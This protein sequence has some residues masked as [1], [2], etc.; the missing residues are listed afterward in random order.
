MPYHYRKSALIKKGIWLYFFLLLFEGALRKWI[1]PNLAAPLLI[2]RDPIAFWILLVSVKEKIIVANVYLTGLLGVGIVG[3]FT[4]IFLGHG[5]MP[6]AIFGARIFLLHLPLIFVIGQVFTRTDVLQLGKAILVICIPMTILIGL[7]FFSPQTAW[8]NRAIG[9]VVEEQGFQGAM[10]HFR[11]PGTFSFI[12]GTY[13]FYS[14]AFSFIIYFALTKKNINSF[15]LVAS[16]LS[17][18]IAIPFSISRTLLFEVALTIAFA[19]VAGTQHSKYLGRLISGTIITII[20]LVSLST[21]SFFHHAT[22]TF[23]ARFSDASETEGGL[24]GTLGDRFLGGLLSAVKDAGRLP[25]FGYGIGM[26]TNVGSQLMSGKRTFLLHE[27]EWGRCIDELGPLIGLLLIFLRTAFCVKLA[28]SGFKRLRQGD[29][30]PWLLLSFGFLQLL[31]GNWSQPTSL[32]FCTLS[33]GMILASLR[34]G[35]QN[36][37]P[38]KNFKF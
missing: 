11:P 14:L 23:F 31:Q 26:G 16:M 2:V 17:V 34:N 36:N 15:L 29:L 35:D 12:T 7:Q 18:L 24:K 32:G 20:I 33:T 22:E 21:T 37:Y 4:A 28:R 9:G 5:S 3:F 6:V 30:L 19:F 27:E 1:L 10:G 25:F 38:D 13:L 8:V